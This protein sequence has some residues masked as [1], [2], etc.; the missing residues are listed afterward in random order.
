MA[1]FAFINLLF[2]ATLRCHLKVD[3]KVDVVKKL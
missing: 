1:Y 3:L 2:P